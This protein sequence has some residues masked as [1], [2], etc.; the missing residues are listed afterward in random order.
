[1]A[2]RKVKTFK[3]CVCRIGYGFKEFEV[4]APSAIAAQQKALDEAGNHLYSE[5]D[6]KYEVNH[7]EEIKKE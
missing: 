7:V 4:Q 5:H 1:M 3:V 6:A 2:K